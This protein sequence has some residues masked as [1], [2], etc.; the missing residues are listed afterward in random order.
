MWPHGKRR[1]Q[2]QPCNSRRTMVSITCSARFTV[3]ETGNVGELLAAIFMKQFACFT[4]DFLKR[5]EAVGDK[6]GIDD[7]NPLDAVL[8]QFLDGLVS[9]GLQPSSGPKRDWKVGISFS[10][11]QPSVRAPGAPFSGTGNDRGRP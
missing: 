8:R 11:G 10:L 1:G 4:G 7:G 3:I 2:I 9:V 5:F 6:S